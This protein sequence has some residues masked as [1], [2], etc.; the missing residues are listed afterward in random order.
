V[1]CHLEDC[2]PRVST[3]PGRFSWSGVP[4]RGEA[5]R[6]VGACLLL[7]MLSSVVLA[8]LLVTA[9]VEQNPDPV[10]EDEMV[11]QLLCTGC[12]RNLRSGIQCEFYGCWYHYNC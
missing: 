5:N 8:V 4:R 1:G 12:A 11:V 7:T 6:I 3:R 2:R 9:G 10:A